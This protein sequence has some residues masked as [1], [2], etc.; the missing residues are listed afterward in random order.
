MRT[1]QEIDERSLARAIVEKIDK[2]PLRQ[3]L[4]RARDTRARW[5]PCAVIAEWKAILQGDWDDIRMVLLDES[6]DGQRLRQSSPFCGVLAPRERWEM[7]RRFC[8]E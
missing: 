6:D 4:Q 3:G 8:H 7:Y 2:D 5:N 1:H